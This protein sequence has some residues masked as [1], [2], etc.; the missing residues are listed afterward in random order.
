MTS[1]NLQQNFISSY[2]KNNQKSPLRDYWKILLLT[3]IFFGIPAIQYVFFQINTRPHNIDKFDNYIN[4]TDVGDICYFNFKC[5]HS[6]W[7][8]YCF[9][10][11]I[12][13]IF[14]IICGLIFIIIVLVSK[15]H[16]DKNIYIAIG[17]T[18]ILEG[19]FSALYHVCPN[20]SNFQFDTTYMMIGVIL[21]IISY[22]QKGSNTKIISFFKLYGYMAL[23]IMFNTLEL[24]RIEDNKNSVYWSSVGCLMLISCIYF[25][26]NVLFG[27]NNWNLKNLICCCSYETKEKCNFYNNENKLILYILIFVNIINWTIY[28]IAYIYQLHFSTMILVVLTMNL[29]VLK[30][31]YFAK[32]IKNFEKI[33]AYIW[34]LLVIS[35]AFWTGAL[36]FFMQNTTNKF[37]TPEQSI[38][39]NSKCVLFDYFDTH[40]I[41]H[42]LSSLGMLNLLLVSWFINY[43]TKK[44]HFIEDVIDILEND[45]YDIR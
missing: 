34:F 7:K 12:S 9:N 30:I 8:L 4:A 44:V 17:I 43:H 26:A 1:N 40:D 39:F 15:N 37:L 24:T 38:E 22:F 14:Y 18:T 13:N 31:Y 3:S 11:I 23:L 27:E 5:C 16:E 20:R 25:S 45:E 36:Y 29:A 28:I 33:P 2:E 32:K 19:L 35:F 6:L 10:N 41:W 42:F 21:M